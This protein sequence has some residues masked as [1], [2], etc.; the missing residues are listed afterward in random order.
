LVSLSAALHWRDSIR[1][2]V[3]AKAKI[4]LDFH[5]N[6]I[7]SHVAARSFDFHKCAAQSSAA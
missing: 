2:Q 4:F 5:G 3:C 1:S 7:A 6:V